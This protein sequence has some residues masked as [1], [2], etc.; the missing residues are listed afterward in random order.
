M[1]MTLEQKK[2]VAIAKARLRAKQSGSPSSDPAATPAPKLGD[3]GYQRVD[4][5][6][7]YADEMLFGLPGKAA[8]A[9]QAGLRAPFTEKSFG[10]EYDAMRQSYTDAR[11]RYAE[12]NPITNAVASVG[13]S[14]HGGATLTAGLG[15]VAAQVAPRVASAVQGSYAGKMATDAASGAAQGAASAYGHDQ[16]ISTGALLGG[17]VGGVARPIMDAGG[18]V[19]RS[20]GGL[21]GLGNETRANQAVAEALMRSGRTA[22]DVADDLARAAADGQPEYMV[23]DALGNSGQRMLAGVARSPGDMRQ[24]IAETLQQR[25]AGQGE[26]LVNALSEGFDAPKTA[27]QTRDAMTAARKSAADVNYEAAR[28][29]AGVVDPTAAIKAADDFLTPGASAVMSPQS[30]IADDSIEAAVRKARGYLTDGNSVLTDFNAAFRAKVELDNMIDGAKPAVQ[31]QLKPIRDALD[32]ALAT[33]S[34]PYAAARDQFRRES[35]AIEAV[36][37]GMA[38]SSARTR[39]SD[40]IGQFQQM[41]PDQQQPFRVGYV[42][43]LI[44]RVEAASMS[45]GTNKARML[46]TEKTGQEFPAFAAP[47]RA[48]VLGDRIAREQRMFQT[49][50]AALGGSKTADNLSDIADTQTFDPT[51]IGALLSPNPIRAVAIQAL[52]RGINTVQGRNSQ[53]RDMIAKALLET[54]PTRA[55]AALANA[56]ASGQKMTRNQEAIIRALIAGGSTAIPRAQ[57]Y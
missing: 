14:I 26:R 25:Q 39:A 15:N 31:R 37:L 33:T 17:V 51:M 10:E 48:D 34:G 9:I 52:Q 6:M 29:A 45:P 5:A 56:V 50:N 13:G 18:A 55:K 41:T 53:T 38:A 47:G 36:D 4:P 2:A 42:D 11:K 19:L 7:I 23:A 57:A 3:Q 28:Q 20:V 40:N 30:G 21:V 8:N 43:P 22:D 35:K 24:T 16:D 49:A 27:A 12:E 32:D 44:A 1:E 46:I 54:G